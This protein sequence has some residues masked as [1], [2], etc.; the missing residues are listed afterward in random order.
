MPKYLRS[1]PS[2][3]SQAG[4]RSVEARW[5]PRSGKA[6]LCAALLAAGCAAFAGCSDAVSNRDADGGTTIDAGGRPPFEL[7]VYVQPSIT[8]RTP[9]GGEPAGKSDGGQVCTWQSVAG[10][11][12][13]GRQYRE[14]ADCN[15]VRTQRP[16]F[17]MPPAASYQADDPRMKDPTFVTELN[18]VR[19]QIDAVGCSCCHSA[20]GPKGAVR[21]SIDLP[22]N[23]ST[24]MNDRDVAALANWIDT[25]MFEKFPKET[26]NG[27]SRPHGLPSTD[28]ARVEAF[29]LAEAKQRGLSA[30]QFANAPPT[31]GPLVEQSQYTPQRCSAGEGIDAAGAIKWNDGP[32]RYVYVLAVGSKNPTVPPDRDT[33]AGTRWRVDVPATGEPLLPGTVRYGVLPPRTFQHFPES[34]T[35]QAL[36]SGRDYYLYVTR[37]MFQPITRCIFTAP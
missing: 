1:S 24:S 30:A 16:Y 9:S 18:W 25:S 34:G 28:P 26:N 13:E 4:F 23:W 12:E 21:W 36:V 31:G 10:A 17:P 6:L 37:D 7:P 22:G 3:H 29:F 11:T 35:A 2:F 33:P 14:Y 20:S 5:C 27:F 8:C 15:V 32:A 19:A